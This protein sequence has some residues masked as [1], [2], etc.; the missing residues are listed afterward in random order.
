MNNFIKAIAIVSLATSSI[1]QAQLSASVGLSSSYAFRGLNFIDRIV[2]SA[3]VKYNIAGFTAG[4]SRNQI[5]EDDERISGTDLNIGYA[6]DVAGQSISIVYNDHSLSNG[7]SRTGWE[8]ITISTSIFGLGVSYS[9]GD[10]SQGSESEGYTAISLDITFG[11]VN[12]LV[13]DQ[14]YDLPAADY[15]YFQLSAPLGSVA[16]LDVGI[17]YLGTFAEAE[18]SL[19]LGPDARNDSLILSARKNFDL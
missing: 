15:K 11:N 7:S 19:A 16:G 18:D 13:S 12:I 4:A 3:E 17:K 14:S 1:T 6:T 9:D 8:D 5:D 2:P 10:I